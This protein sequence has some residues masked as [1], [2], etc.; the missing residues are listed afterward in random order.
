MGIQPMSASNQEGE[1]ITF[2]DDADSVDQ[3]S[4]ITRDGDTDSSDGEEQAPP[5][6]TTPTDEADQ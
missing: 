3:P 2:I 4:D 6:A 5:A 1:V